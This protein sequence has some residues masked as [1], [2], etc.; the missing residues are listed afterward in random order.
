VQPPIAPLWELTRAERRKRDAIRKEIRP[1]ES[2]KTAEKI[3]PSAIAH[4]PVFEVHEGQP[5]AE[6]PPIIKMPVEAYAA[7]TRPVAKGEDVKT[8]IAVLLASKSGLRNAI[9]LREIF[10]P[11]RSLQPLD[12]VGSA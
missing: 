3:F 11:P 1:P 7:V 8:D 2:A 12:L 5:P 6:P 4:A 10:G 9:I